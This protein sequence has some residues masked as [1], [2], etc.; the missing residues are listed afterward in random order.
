M[1]EE[2]FTGHENRECGEH[3]TTGSR[4]WCFNCNEWCYP[5][6]PCVGCEIVPLREFAEKHGYRPPW[7]ENNV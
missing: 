3:R 1:T 7:E 2:Y 6:M 4:A 5:Q